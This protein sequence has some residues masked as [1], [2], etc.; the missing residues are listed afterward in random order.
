LL[1]AEAISGYNMPVSNGIEVKCQN[2]RIQQTEYRRQETEGRREKYEKEGRLG[3][4]GKRRLGRKG[5]FVKQSQFLSG[6]NERKTN[7]NKGL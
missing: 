1:Y 5:F 3:F 4:L 7:K 2:E 6:Q